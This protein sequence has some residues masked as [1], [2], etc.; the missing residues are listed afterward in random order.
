[1]WQDIRQNFRG[2]LMSCVAR[3][4]YGRRSSGTISCD[5]PRNN[6]RWKPLNYIFVGSLFNF[7]T[8][9]VKF[10][11]KTITAVP[12]AIS[13]AMFDNNYY[14]IICENPFQR[15]MSCIMCIRIV[16]QSAILSEEFVYMC[17]VMTSWSYAENESML[18]WTQCHSLSNWNNIMRIMDNFA[19]KN[20]GWIRLAK[21]GNIL[22]KIQNKRFTYLQFLIFVF[23]A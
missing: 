6:F 5:T 16:V 7:C 12:I 9:K 11:N 8:K 13:S 20:Y 3:S 15:I 23:K 10:S 22:S 1:M 18:H 21:M 19:D 17:I 4:P 14:F 2:Q